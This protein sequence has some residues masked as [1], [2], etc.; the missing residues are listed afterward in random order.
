MKKSEKVGIIIVVILAVV[1]AVSIFAGGGN[2]N[3]TAVKNPCE[4]MCRPMNAEQDEWSFPKMGPNADYNNTGFYTKEEC[5]SAC[6]SA[7]TNR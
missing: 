1:F 2:K 6:K 4:T 7:R 5:V 3:Q